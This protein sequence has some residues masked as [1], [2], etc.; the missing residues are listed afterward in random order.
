MITAEEALTRLKD[1]NKRFVSDNTD[2]EASR[3][4]NRRAELV[5]KQEPF[6]IILGCSDSR[7]PS[8]LVFDQGIGDLFV[9]RVAG[10]IAASS[11]IASIEF[12]AQQFNTKLVVVMG[13]TNCG[14][15]SATL[16]EVKNPSGGLSESLQSIVDKI[17]PS[18]E[19]L[20]E[21]DLADQPDNLLNAAVHSNVNAGVSCLQ[22]DSDVLKQL[23][24]DNGLQV[25]GA[26][27]SLETGEVKFFDS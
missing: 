12:C 27:Y 21:T 15:I 20:L 11:Q 7:V 6:A 22:N 9:V 1:G 2:S 25:V 5:R 17:R 23:A 10:N 19:P 24:A 18:V 8:E 3:S 16:S 4:S 26:E 13:H 14:A